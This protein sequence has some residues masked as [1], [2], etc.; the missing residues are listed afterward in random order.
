MQVHVPINVVTSTLRPNV[1]Y[2]SVL[3]RGSEKSSDIQEE[4]RLAYVGVTRAMDRLFILSV[5]VSQLKMAERGKTNLFMN[6]A[7]IFTKDLLIL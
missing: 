1:S 7:Y 6:T 3:H 2:L 5:K 4:K